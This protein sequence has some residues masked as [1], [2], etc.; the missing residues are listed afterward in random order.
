MNKYI[1]WIGI[2]IIA[3]SSCQKENNAEALL[4]TETPPSYPRC[5]ESTI[6]ELTN[7]VNCSGESRI[8]EYEY[9]D[10]LIYKF[11]IDQSDCTFNEQ[12][13][14]NKYYYGDCMPHEINMLFCGSDP[15]FE[16]FHDKIQFKQIVWEKN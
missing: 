4:L 8:E 5:F 2:F 13:L 1:I 16:I 14:N 9:E 10:E 6:T 3:L 15:F 11:F 12:H 7:N